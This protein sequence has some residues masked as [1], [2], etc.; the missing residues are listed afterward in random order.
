MRTTDEIFELI[1]LMLPANTYWGY[2][3]KPA[4][5]LKFKYI[6]NPLLECLKKLYAITLTDDEI[7]GFLDSFPDMTENVK[8]DILTTLW[9]IKLN[10]TKNRKT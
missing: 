2:K 1:W 9:E 4:S 8:Y 7:R 6:G 5:I 10:A 3:N